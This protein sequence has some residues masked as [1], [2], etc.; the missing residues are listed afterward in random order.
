VIVDNKMFFKI[1]LAVS[2]FGVLSG[3]AIHYK[4]LQSLWYHK[5]EGEVVDTDI[6]R[7]GSDS[8]GYEVRIRYKYFV[9]GKEYVSNRA[10]AG[11]R[12]SYFPVHDQAV[13]FSNRYP[14]NTRTEIFY[15][16]SDPEISV[17]QPGASRYAA[18]LIITFSFLLGVFAIYEWRAV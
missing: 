10:T 3:S 15:D 16:P 11:T 6:I 2:F 18:L 13:E 17:L 1:L 7:V 8:G 12:A 9:N 14:V 5:T 4:D